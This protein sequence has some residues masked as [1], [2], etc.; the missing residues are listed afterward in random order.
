MLESVTLRSRA[1]E[2]TSFACTS[3]MSDVSTYAKGKQHHSC[4]GFLPREWSLLSTFLR[5]MRAQD[6]NWALAIGEEVLHLRPEKKN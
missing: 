3:T 2:R 1:A 6:Y 5:S 4:R